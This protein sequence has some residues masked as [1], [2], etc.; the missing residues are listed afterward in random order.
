M[1]SYLELPDVEHLAAK[2]TVGECVKGQAHTIG[3]ES[4]WLLLKP[5]YIGKFHKLSATNLLRYVREFAGRAN[6]RDWH[7]LTQIAMLAYG[8]I[9]KRTQYQDLTALA[10]SL[11]MGTCKGNALKGSGVSPA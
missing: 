5:R 4:F 6:V 3:M 8:M 10:R 7:T 11:Q 9:G 2:H 1:H